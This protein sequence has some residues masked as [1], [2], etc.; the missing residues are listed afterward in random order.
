MDSC[1]Y[2][3]LAG[4]MDSDGSFGIKRSTYHLRVRGDAVNPI[5]YERASLK[6][7]TPEIPMLLKEAFG[8]SLRLNKGGTENS[9]PLHGWEATAKQ[10]A[11]AVR[12][13]RPYLRV[14]AAQA[15]ALLELRESHDPKY[16]QP[17]YW[18]AL[19]HP[20]WRE[21]DMIT[22]S[23]A[24]AILGHTHRNSV[25]QSIRNGMLLALPWDH[26]GRELPRIPRALVE[27]LAQNLSKDGRARIQPVELV[28]WRERIC[29]RVRGLNKIGVNGTPVY[30]REGCYTPAE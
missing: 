25:S 14:K 29:E 23:E 26:S 22:T 9:K 16:L 15:D 10:A 19:E 28:A 11:E 24:A 12:L 20:G 1:V 5:F 4:A 7:V 13:M 2:A 6:Q 3:Y 21:M 8:G 30:R 17:A 27:R 18:F